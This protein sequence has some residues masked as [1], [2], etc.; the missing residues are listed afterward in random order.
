MVASISFIA[1][2][3]ASYMMM[4]YMVSHSREVDQLIALEEQA[5][6]LRR[7]CAYDADH[8]NKNTRQRNQLLVKIA[9]KRK[10]IATERKVGARE[11]NRM[12]AARRRAR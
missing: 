9:R 6:Q 7:R 2:F 1:L 4:N 3:V 12:V 10:A 11:I 5:E 8:R